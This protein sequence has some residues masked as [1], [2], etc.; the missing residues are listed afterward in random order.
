MA[1]LHSLRLVVSQEAMNL[2]LTLR[3]QGMS[4]S[5]GIQSLADRLEA[6]FWGQTSAIV[7]LAEYPTS[8]GERQRN[9]EKELMDHLAP[10]VA[11]FFQMG[12]DGAIKQFSS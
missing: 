6:D 8:E 5:K 10:K 1:E 9:R 3:A 11:S 12:F 4:Y 7:T 2:T